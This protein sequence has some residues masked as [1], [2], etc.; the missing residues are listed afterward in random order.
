MA[1]V[2]LVS[3]AG[4]SIN[5]HYCNTTGTESLSLLPFPQSCHH[6]SMDSCS[7]GES[8]N[9]VESCCASAPI[10]KPEQQKVKKTDCCEDFFQYMKSLTELELPKISIKKLFNKFLLMMVRVIELVMP[11]HSQE[12]RPTA[13]LHKE[14]PPVSGKYIVIAYHQLKIAHDLL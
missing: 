12:A 2:V 8:S 5:I 13:F 9:T 4:L 1:V 14:S 6:N 3:S 10:K 11:S 7:I